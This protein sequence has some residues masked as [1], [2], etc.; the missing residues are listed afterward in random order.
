MAMPVDTLQLAQGRNGSATLELTLLDLDAVGDGGKGYVLGNGYVRTASLYHQAV[1]GAASSCLPTSSVEGAGT[2][3][4]NR[5]G[6]VGSSPWMPNVVDIID[7]TLNRIVATIVLSVQFVAT[8]IPPKILHN[9]LPVNNESVSDEDIGKKSQ[10]ELSLKEAF[11]H[12]DT[13]NSGSVSAQELFAVI[14]SSR[15]NH[16]DENVFTSMLL[17]SSPLAKIGVEC[18]LFTA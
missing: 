2:S 9:I 14:K 15:Y 6:S 13:D 17:K 7:R 12:A 5:N 16:R 3:N 1:R 10:M 4:G 18:V 11:I 8:A